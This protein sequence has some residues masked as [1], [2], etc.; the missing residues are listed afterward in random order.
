MSETVYI[1]QRGS[2]NVEVVL[3]G[4]TAVRK[5]GRRETTLHE[6]KPKDEDLSF[7]DWVQLDKLF[8]VQN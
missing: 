3:T 8:V 2:E 7:S 4:R 6:I 5:T 1:H